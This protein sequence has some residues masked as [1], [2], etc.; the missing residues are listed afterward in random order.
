MKN[1]LLDTFPNRIFIVLEIDN[2]SKSKFY[3][4]LNLSRTTILNWRR[5]AIPASDKLLNISNY[6]DVHPTW[7]L[8]GEIERSEYEKKIFI[9]QCKII[10]EFIEKNP[11]TELLQLFPN[12]QLKKILNGMQIFT[13]EQLTQLSISMNIPL[14][15][16]I[17]TEDSKTTEYDKN[18][19]MLKYLNDIN[20]KTVFNVIEA[21]YFQ[22]TNK[23]G[24]INK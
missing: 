11:G 9:N 22:E 21:L 3:A 14:S 8:Y 13:L 18:I 5:G 19:D 2:I 12:N 20:K 10:T 24:D 6:L 17:T 7:L 16:L 4:D 15:T 23:K 1:I